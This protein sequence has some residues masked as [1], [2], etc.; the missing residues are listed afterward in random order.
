MFVM[1]LLPIANIGYT[2]TNMGIPINGE[3][4]TECGAYAQWTTIQKKSKSE[5]LSLASNDETRG[6]Y[7]YWKKKG[8]EWQKLHFSSFMEAIKWIWM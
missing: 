1:A 5:I 3:W 4:I 2:I 8:T 7:I 6:C